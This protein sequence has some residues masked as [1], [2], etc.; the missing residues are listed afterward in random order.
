M[1]PDTYFGGRRVGICFSGG[2]DS[3]YL[4]YLA[5]SLGADVV[6]FYADT[7]FDRPEDRVRANEL[8]ARIGARLVHVPVGMPPEALANGPDRC[9]VCKTAIMSAIRG[10]A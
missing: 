2:L 10:G 5:V 7:P 1:D 8:C 3:T 6:A 4:L 9:Y